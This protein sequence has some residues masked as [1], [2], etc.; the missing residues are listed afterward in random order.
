MRSRIGSFFSINLSIKYFPISFFA[1]ALGMLGFTLS[2]RK[3]EQVLLWNIH[4][5]F[6]L[7]ILST[8]VFALISGVY[9]LKIALFP[10]EV[11]EEFSDPV[12]MNFFPLFSICFLLLNIILLDTNILIS[13]TLWVI[14]T[15][16]H[17]FFTL[18]IVSQWMHHNNFDITSINPAWFIP[19][20]G[21][22]LIPISGV[23]HMSPEISWFFFSIGIVF[24]IVLFTIVFYRII[25][26]HPVVM[27]LLPTF[28]I[29]I[30]PP[31][32][33]AMSYVKL[34]GGSL[35]AFARILY[36]FSFFTLLLLLT[37]IKHFYKLQFYL[38]WWSYSFPIA[39]F[40]SSSLMMYQKTGLDFFRIISLILLSSLSVLVIFLFG[41][42]LQS[43]YQNKICI[44]DTGCST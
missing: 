21:N 23:S 15:T 32:I 4:P 9:I 42:T 19:A 6:F 18:K 44:E 43:L 5:S 12:K 41:K 20:V 36:Y 22:I 35:D 33:G 11:G 16:I 10:E 30:A 40:I 13:K 38:S 24:W 8:I 2:V 25:F 7:L 14:G 29:L 1:M 39:A 31:A 3:A 34:T 37:Q 27:K 26:H 17:L 28:F